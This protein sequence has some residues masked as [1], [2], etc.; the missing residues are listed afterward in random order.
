MFG[1]EHNDA[2]IERMNRV[3]GTEGGSREGQID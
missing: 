1:R 3:D 2:L